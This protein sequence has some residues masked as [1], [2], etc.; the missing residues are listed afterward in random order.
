MMMKK[1]L[2]YILIFPVFFVLLYPCFLIVW[3]SIT[4]NYFRSN[5]NYR[6]GSNGHLNSRLREVKNVKDIDILFL[7]SSHTY[8][9]FDTRIFA[10]YGFTSFNLGSSSQTPLQTKVLLKRYLEQL[11]PKLII[12]EV[13][14][15]AFSQDGAEAALDL[16]ANDKNDLHSLRMAL[17]I[18]NYKV[19]NTLLF[20][21]IRNYFLTNKMYAEPITK[22]A[23]TYVS[24]GYVERR[25]LHSEQVDIGKSYSLKWK[26]EISQFIALSEI[27]DLIKER[28]I[29]VLFVNAPVPRIRYTSFPSLYEFENRIGSFGKYLDFNKLITLDEARY[30][31]DENHLNQM[32]VDTFNRS[33][34]N[35]IKE[36]YSRPEERVK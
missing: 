1:F 13:C 2:T 10:E 17:E 31:F 32:G 5:L 28:K 16:I 29:K 22:G 15:P 27:M 12:Y 9:G 30:F 19:Y 6:I 14:P 20:A 26:Y 36:V 25:D 4:P 3:Y 33:L 18:N 8:R 24:G 35:H 7:G 23:D 21:M 34:I 11:N